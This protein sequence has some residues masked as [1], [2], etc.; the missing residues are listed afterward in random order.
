MIPVEREASRTLLSEDCSAGR[1]SGFICA[2][3][4]ICVCVLVQHYLANRMGD[5]AGTAAW[6]A[7]DIARNQQVRE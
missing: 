7:G 2:R 1:K 4:C 6:A 5:Q 3:V